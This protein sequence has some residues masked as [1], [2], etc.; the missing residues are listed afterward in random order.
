[1]DQYKYIRVLKTKMLPFARRDFQGNFVFQD[2]APAHGARRVM[3]FLEN[4]NVQHMDWPAMSPDLNPVENLDNLPT[5]VA[6]LTQAVVNIWRDIPAEAL[7]PRFEHDSTLACREV[8]FLHIAWH[9]SS[10]LTQGQIF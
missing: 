1:M 9:H 6:E 4:E 8:F 7:N 3:D 5:K 2:D 10:A